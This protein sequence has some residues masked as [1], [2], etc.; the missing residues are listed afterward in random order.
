[1]LIVKTTDAPPSRVVIRDEL[2]QRTGRG[3]RGRR[4]DDAVD[5]LVARREIGDPA[6]VIEQLSQRDP[7]PV[8]GQVR[9][10]PADRVPEAQQVI[11]DEQEGRRSRECL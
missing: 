10:I 4:L 6:G 11:R 7:M 5:E 9:Q 2:E 1:V 3:R 8:L